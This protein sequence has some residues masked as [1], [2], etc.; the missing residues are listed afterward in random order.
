MRQQAIHFIRAIKGE[1]K[2]PCEAAEALADLEV[3][4][5]YI[6]LWKGA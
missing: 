2:P 6:R 4:R 3:A 5:D 1:I